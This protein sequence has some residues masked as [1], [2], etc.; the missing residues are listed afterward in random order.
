MDDMDSL[1]KN[2]DRFQR[3]VGEWADGAF[4]E[5]TPQTILSHLREELAELEESVGWEEAADVF[6]LLLHLAHKLRFSLIGG[7]I[8]KDA[9]NRQRTWETDDS[10]RGHW[11]HIQQEGL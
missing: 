2:V 9:V 1:A 11:K 10:G 6:L 3:N 8:T 4:P 5:S 7:A